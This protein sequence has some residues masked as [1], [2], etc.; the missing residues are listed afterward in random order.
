MT[1]PELPAPKYVDLV[2]VRASVAEYRLS[3]PEASMLDVAINLARAAHAGQ[4]DKAGVDY[5]RHPLEVMRRV[6]TNDEKIVA[7]F[8]DVVED[9]A[10]TLDYLRTP[11]F[12][13]HVVRA[14]DAVTKRK[15]GPLAELM[16]RVAANPLALIVKLADISHNADPVRQAGLSGEAQARLTEKYAKLAV[17]L[18]TTLAQILAGHR[19]PRFDGRIADVRGART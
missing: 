7:V 19:K 3:R 4:R 12:E 8:H 9:T 6:S 13:E 17:F 5:I 11:G 16:A 10:V 18:G 14:M 2:D 15:G 1:N